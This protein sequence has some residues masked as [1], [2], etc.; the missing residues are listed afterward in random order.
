MRPCY[1]APMLGSPFSSAKETDSVFI[2]AEIGK[3]FIQTEEDRSVEE[4]L[5]NAKALIAAAQDAG[6]DAVKFQTHVVED[7]QLPI[8][9]RSPHFPGMDRYRWVKRNTEATPPDFWR[10]VSEYCKERNIL[11]FSTPMSRSAA[12]VLRP[13]DM[14]FWKVSSA[15]ALD[16]VLLTELV[17]TGKPI[18]LSTGMV[19]YK[20]LAAVHAF[21]AGRVPLA[22]LYCVS[23]YPCPPEEFNL[24][25]IQRLKKLYP[26][27]VIGFSDHS[28]GH[29]VTL[30]A[31]RRGARI[32]EKHFSMER[33][34]WGSDHKISLTPKECEAMVRA[35]RKGEW[36]DTDTSP[37]DG[38]EE[39]ELE[40]ATNA[41]RPYFEKKLAAA[42]DMTAGEIWDTEA[43]FAMRPAAESKGLPSFKFPEILGRTV[44]RSLRKYDPVTSDSLQ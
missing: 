39:R 40:G 17:Q 28:L 10:A 12:R 4:Y 1:C 26:E 23:K 15:D 22:I 30:A 37:Y 8:A 32:I 14:P 13:F 3:N 7:E 16:F 36:K 20:E 44:A 35:I 18:I 29:D 19:S 11:F 42:R 9:I 24:L 21:I 31:I 6:V 5:A 27:A 34:L 43:L 2:V 38:E 41:L 25:S 33:T